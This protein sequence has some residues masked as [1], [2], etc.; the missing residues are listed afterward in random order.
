MR[1]ATAVDEVLSHRPGCTWEVHRNDGEQSA[2][3][4][5]VSKPLEKACSYCLGIHI[6]RELSEKRNEDRLRTYMLNGTTPEELATRFLAA[7]KECGYALGWPRELDAWY[8]V[9]KEL[10]AA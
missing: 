5:G 3:Y 8:E 10:I 2:G 7:V 6:A 1:W 9:F 4:S